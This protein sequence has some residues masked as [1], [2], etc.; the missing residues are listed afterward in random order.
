MTVGRPILINFREPATLSELAEYIGIERGLLEKAIQPNKSE[1]LYTKH[2]IP[3]RSKNGTDN[4]RIVWE[5]DCLLLADAYKSLARR[6]DLFVTS[7]CSDYPHSSAFG[8]IRGRNTIDNARGHCLATTILHA[9]IENFFPSISRERIATLFK[10]FG[11]HTDIAEALSQFVTIENVLP[12]G[13]HSSP[14]LANLICLEM[15]VQFKKLADKYGCFYTRYADDITISGNADVPKKEE[16]K[17]LLADE[18]FILSERKFRITRLGQKHYVTGLS[19]ADKKPHAPRLMKKRLR[20]ELH[21]CKKFGIE[22]HLIHIKEYLRHPDGKDNF[23]QRGLNRIDGMVRYISNIEDHLLPKIRGGWQNSLNEA[24]LK[25]SYQTV[26]GSTIK[27]VT[28]YVDETVIKHNNKRYLA[29]SFVHAI[30]PNTI[31]VETSLVL[32]SYLAS[33]FVLGDKD[34]LRKNGLHYVDADEDLRKTYI[35]RLTNFP[36]RSYLV[37]KELT[38]EGDYENCFISL[39]RKIMPHRLM[40]CDGAI[41]HIIFE[42][43]SKIRK[44]KIEETINEVYKSLKKTRNRCA[45]SVH[46]SIGKKTQFV[47]FSVPDFLLGIFSKYARYNSTEERQLRN[48]EQSFFESLRDKY[49]VIL[50]ADTNIVYSRK[51]PFEPWV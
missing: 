20:Q 2:Q 26:A 36:F 46:V 44:T 19:V 50:D 7:V 13:L 18:G 1:S 30:A 48:R 24:G 31:S 29:L 41:V 38:S 3:K 35:S 47:N 5:A 43:N 8:Y 14:L 27:C 21:Y 45:A 11:L 32:R 9:D 39:I 37:Y 28:F 25:P 40:A 22:G 15:D 17:S 12:L 42:E 33:P 6:F 16:V 51:R 49:R 23:V 34:A 10:R 4:Y